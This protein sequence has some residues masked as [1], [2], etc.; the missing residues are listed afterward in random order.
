MDSDQ[1]EQ[2]CMVFYK[3]LSL[4][5]NSS[6]YMEKISGDG[7]QYITLINRPLMLEAKELI[8]KFEASEVVG[9][10]RIIRAAFSGVD[11]GIGNRLTVRD[12]SQNVEII[13][14][15]SWREFGW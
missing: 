1:I 3:Q 2:Y 10:K 12:T 5:C 4:I 14:T 6:D 7:F 11:F 13:E 15:E 9:V 8:A